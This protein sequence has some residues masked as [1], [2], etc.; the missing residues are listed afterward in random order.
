[1]TIEELH[2]RRAELIES[3]EQVLANFHSH[4]GAISEVEGWINRLSAETIDEESIDAE[5]VG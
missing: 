5:E 2:Q 4:L 3:K 1:M